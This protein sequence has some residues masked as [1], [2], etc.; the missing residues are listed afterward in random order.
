MQKSPGE[1][2]SSAPDKDSHAHAVSTHVSSK[3][4]QGQAEVGELRA[5]AALSKFRAAAKKVVVTKEVR[6]RCSSI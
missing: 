6:S 3:L 4:L 2:T 1:L 5:G